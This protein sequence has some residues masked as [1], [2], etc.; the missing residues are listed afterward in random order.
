MISAAPAT[1]RGTLI[2]RPSTSSGT[3][4]LAAAATAIT[5]SRLIT[6]SAIATICT[7][8][9]RCDAA[10]DAFLVLVFRHQQLC[11]DHEQRQATDQ[12]EVRQLHQRHDD[13]GEDDA[14][15]NG[16]AG[17]QDHAPE[18]LAR[19]QPTAC[20]RDDQRV[21][22][23]QQHVDPHDLAERD[24]ERRL[25]H[26]G[27]KLGEE[28]R[29]RRR[30]EDLQHPVHSIC[31]PGQRP[32]CAAIAC[33]FRYKLFSR[34]FR[35]PRRTGRFRSRRSRWRPNHAPSF[36]RSSW[37]AVCGWCRRRPWKDRWRP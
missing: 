21:V 15:Q 37:R 25:L 3:L 2:A 29:D 34:R 20:H 33:R 22:A 4:P 26:L 35:C 19:L 12:L 7:A 6:M 32:S 23:R 16:D 17:A 27:L 10:S 13:A 5:L 18:P 31:P 28:V 36:R 1:I 30:I 14:Q 24:P 11:R 9:H 8:A